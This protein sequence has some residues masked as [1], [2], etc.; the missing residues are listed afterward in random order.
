MDRKAR[1]RNR[2]DADLA[3]LQALG[4]ERLVVAIGKFAAKTGKKKER[5]DQSRAGKR[6]QGCRIGA[7][8]LEKND[9]DKR[10]LEKVVAKRREKLTPEQRRETARRQQ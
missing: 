1:D 3:K 7:A 2:G 4:D 8:D 6:D 10:G 9:K 5:R